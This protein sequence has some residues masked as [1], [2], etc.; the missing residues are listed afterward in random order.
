MILWKI[1]DA[2]LN[3]NDDFIKYLENIKNEPRHMYQLV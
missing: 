2:K 3:I 1:H